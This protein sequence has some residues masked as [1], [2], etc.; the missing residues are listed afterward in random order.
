MNFA[1]WFVF[2]GLMPAL[3]IFIFETVCWVLRRINRDDAND[4]VEHADEAYLKE[5]LLLKNSTFFR[6]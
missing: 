4:D 1:F 6:K 3:A 2:L 5:S